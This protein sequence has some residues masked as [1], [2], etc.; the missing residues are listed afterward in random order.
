MVPLSYARAEED[1]PN[2]ATYV[3]ADSVHVVIRT[4]PLLFADI[5]IR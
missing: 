2:D 1:L 3:V 4:N 5:G